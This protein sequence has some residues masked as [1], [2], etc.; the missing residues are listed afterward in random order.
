MFSDELYL[1]DYRKHHIIHTVEVVKSN[2]NTSWSTII[3][4]YDIAAKK[5]W[6]LFVNSKKTFIMPRSMAPAILLSIVCLIRLFSSLFILW[7]C[8]YSSIIILSL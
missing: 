1:H 5:Y 6:V 8:P 3:S 2:Q 4:A 7:T